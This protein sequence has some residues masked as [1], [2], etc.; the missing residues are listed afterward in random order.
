MG[1]LMLLAATAVLLGYC[2]TDEKVSLFGASYIH[3]PVQEAKGSTDISFRF[4]THLADAI[5]ILA[6]GKTDYCLIKLE[7]GRLKVHINLGAGESEI[8]GPKGLTLNDLNWHE[9]NLTRREANMTLKIDVIHT[10]RILLPGRFFVLNILYGVYIGGRGDFNELFLG[11]TEYMRGCMADILYNGANVIEYT[12]LRKVNSEAT[13]VTWGCSGEFDATEKSEISFIEEGAFISIPKQIPRSGSRWEFELKTISESGLLLYN[14]GQASHADYLGIELIDSKIRLLMNKGNGATEILHKMYVSDGKW[15]K[16]IIEFNPNFIGITIDENSEKLNLPS[17]GN[18]YLDLADIL[19]IGGTELNKRARAIGKGLK[20]GDHSFIGCIKNMLLDNNEIGLPNVKISQG[21]VVGCIWTYPCYNIKPCIETSTCTQL[22]VHSFQCICDQPHCVKTGYVEPSNINVSLALNLEIVAVKSIV[23]PEGEHTLVT[24]NNIAMVLDIAKYG[25]NENGVIFTMVEQPKHGKITLDSTT[26]TTSSFTL[27]DIYSNKVQYIHDGSE[28]EEDFMILEVKL[29]VEIGFTLPEYLQSRLRFPLSVNVTPVND[30]P[31]LEIP[32]TK[33]LR[34]AQGTRK[35]LNKELVWTVDPDTSNDM[36]IYTVLRADTDA[37]H[38]EKLNHSSSRIEKF[39]QAELS[40]GLISYVHHGSAKPNAMLG[41]Q[42]NDGNENSKK[43]FLRITAYPLQIKLKHNTGIVVVHRSFSYLTPFNL[44]FATNSDDTS[45]LILYTI[46]VQPQYGILEVLNSSTNTW[47][48]VEQFTN[49]NIELK[50]IKYL[51]TIGSPT[52]DIFKFQASVRELKT[53]QIFDFKISFID[54][55]LKE[56]NNK[57]IE[58]TNTNEIIITNDNI[59]YQTNPLLTS[60]NMIEYKMLNNP[61]Y[62]IIY[63]KNKILNNNDILTQH[64]IDNGS[65]KY[66]LYKRAYSKIDDEI[67]FLINAPQCQSLT[68]TLTI[69]YLT[70]KNTR[71]I[72]DTIESLEVDEGS[73]VPLNIAKIN[74]KDFQVNDV[75]YNITELPKHGWFILQSNN[76]KTTTTFTYNELMNKSI[77][78]IH[79][80]SETTND[81]FSYVGISNDNSNNDFMYVGKFNI[82]INLKNDNPPIRSGITI[83][84][85]VINGERIITNNELNYIDHDTGTNTNDIIYTVSHITNGNIYNNL[86]EK[87]DKFTQKDINERKIIFKHNGDVNGQFEFD[88]S[89]GLFKH[90]DFL[91]IHASKPYIKFHESNAT[92][93]QFNN[94]VILN[95]NDF[96][97]DTN[98]DIN[99]NDIIYNITSQPKQGKII[100]KNNNECYTFTRNDLLNKLILYKHLGGSLTKDEFRIRINING[101]Y[102]ET[103][104]MI[105]VYP[106][107]Y[108]ETLIIKNN[109]IIFVEEATSVLINKRSLEILH[110]K[111]SPTEITYLIRELPKNGYLEMQNINDGHNINN[112]EEIKD[113]YEINQIRHFDQSVINEGRLYYVQSVANQTNDNFIIDVTNGITWIRGI[114][115]NFIIIPDKLYIESDNISVI[116]GNSILLNRKKFHVITTYYNDKLSDYKIIEKPKHGYIIDVNKNN[117]NIKK[118]TQKQLDNNCIMYKHNGDEFLYDFMKI[119]AIAGDKS[120]QPIDIWINIQQINDELPVIIKNNNIKVWQGGNVVITNDN[121]LAIDNDTLPNDLLYNISIIKNGY[122]SLKK[123]PS[124]EIYNFTQKQINDLSII[125]THTNGTDAVIFFTLYDGIHTITGNNITIDTIPIKLKIIENN[126]LNIFPLTRKIIVDKILLTTCTDNSRNVFYIIRRSPNLGK[127]IMETNEGTWHE[128]DRFTQK[129]LNESKVTYEHT[130]QFMDLSTNDSFVFDV[131]TYFAE[132]IK[133]QI[134]RI[135]VSVSSGGL[136]RYIVSSPIHVEEGGSTEISMNISGIIGY[137]RTKTGI[138]NPSV[139]TTLT[140]QPKHG[141]V[142]LMPDLNITKFSQSQIEDKKIAYYHD[143]SD[144]I[145]DHIDLSLYLIPGYIMLCNTSIQIIISPI[146]DQPFKL[147]TKSPFITVV[148]NQSQTITRNDLLTI[149]PDTTPDELIYDMISGTTAGHLL[150]LSIEQNSSEVRQVN[151][152][153]QLD[154]DS[155][156]LIYEHSGSSQAASF[157]FRVSD[158]RFTPVYTLFNVHVIPIKLNV[159]TP[160]SLTLQQ[161]INMAILTEDNIKLDTNARQ[162]HVIYTLTKLPKYGTLYVKNLEATTF[163]HTDLL[164]KIVVYVQ[165]DMS[166]SNDSLILSSRIS[167]YIINDIKIIIKV[168]PLMLI[169]QMTVFSGEKNQLNLKY[170]DA[171]PLAEATSSNPIYY[172]TTKSRYCKIKRILRN[173]G[174][175][176]STREREISRFSHSEIITGVIFIVCKRIPI[177]DIDGLNDNFEFNLSGSIYQPANGI[178][179]IKIKIDPDINNNTL[180]GPMDPVGHEG[181]MSIAPNMSQDYIIL[182]SMLFGLFILSILVVITIKCRRKKYKNTTTNN[183]INNNNNNMLNKQNEMTPTI[184]VIPLPRPPDHLMPTTPHLKRF[185]NDHMDMTSSTP[186]PTHSTMTTSTLPQ[187]KV[188][189]LNQIESVASSDADVSARYPYGVADND[190]WSSFD[191]ADLPCSQNTVR[192]TNPLLRRNQYWV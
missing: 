16:I 113:D 39:T 165:T 15:H 18:R 154:V 84:D 25:M 67:N 122:L 159:T 109:N 145:D 87:I 136:G 151:K 167:D 142:M 7:A 184:G 101:I 98:I 111:I 162:E 169:R 19:Y 69:E 149:D 49:H 1:L 179:N 77:Y 104:I 20:S 155:N 47:S 118:F 86:N 34:L 89:D 92:I 26:T 71:V 181:E 161:G 37:G 85:V 55:E 5:L 182:L 52:N 99:Y 183:N 88:I 129:D 29:T 95:I 11:H 177:N 31:I 72:L 93:V 139:I 115:I 30:P 189:P 42:V 75:I 90:N 63:N 27:H 59:K 157:Y 166:S 176:R 13:S 137:L 100:M 79:D 35:I 50:Q 163:K 21:I 105:K 32:T 185:V 117:N 51:H 83:F 17:G 144:S 61:K 24:T 82:T 128:V 64:D 41:L 45:I 33:V 121:L 156:R 192:R 190:D 6:A 158:G 60:T 48:S 44:S 12:K 170:M 73:K 175:K 116:E 97:I 4:R 127:I 171:T 108:W 76:N 124:I 148:Q 10:T 68:A 187:C 152:F 110:P 103:R 126:L 173:S 146:N 8:A 140:N 94:T 57:K 133:N 107:C 23:V 2:Q 53:Q 168:I 143:H 188:I 114:V 3:F 46:I 66:R 141:H 56:I 78:Y 164:S 54:M 14:A 130:K 138:E 186:L 58:F 70:G 22:G 119:I 40:Q 106:K 160:S 62:G 191:T 132:T 28:N 43:T 81:T 74:P 172:I 9:I 150:L 135:D 38:V 123:F 147:V 120:S 80:D 180:E 125:F 65:I 153:S 36:L 96:N 178:F 102:S 134:F 174:E 112:N 131:E 91:E